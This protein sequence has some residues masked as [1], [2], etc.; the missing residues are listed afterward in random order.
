ML[1]VSPPITNPGADNTPTAPE[2]VPSCI[3]LH[4]GELHYF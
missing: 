4:E 3:S 2:L 1:V